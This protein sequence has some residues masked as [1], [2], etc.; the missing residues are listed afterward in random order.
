MVCNRHLSAIVA[1][2]D[3]A[4]ALN[5]DRHRGPEDANEAHRLFIHLQYPGE[6]RGNGIDSVTKKMPDMRLKVY[7]FWECEFLELT[8][9]VVNSKSPSPSPR[10]SIPSFQSG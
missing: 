5:Q 6:V 8:R 10:W 3:R 9:F 4:L 1:R 2:I 7:A